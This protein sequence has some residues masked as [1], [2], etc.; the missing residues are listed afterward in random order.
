MSIYILHTMVQK[1]KIIR[2]IKT[3]FKLNH[4]MYIGNKKIKKIIDLLSLKI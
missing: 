2:Q 1:Y 4:I 3:L